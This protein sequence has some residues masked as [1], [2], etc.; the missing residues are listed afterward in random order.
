[1]GINGEIMADDFTDSDGEDCTGPWRTAMAEGTVTRV[2]VAVQNFKG[3]DLDDTVKV[4]WRIR[5][6]S[7]SC[8]QPEVMDGT[9]SP[10]SPIASGISYTVTCN[11]GF[12]ISGPETITCSDGKLSE[13]PE[14]KKPEEEKDSEKRNYS[15]ASLFKI[16]ALLLPSLLAFWAF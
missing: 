16:S 13:I 6:I 5:P 15:G 9:V 1:M 2:L 7:A 14:C 3:N 12:T 11:D 4:E 8:S 10:D